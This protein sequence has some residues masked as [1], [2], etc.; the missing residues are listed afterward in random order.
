MTLGIF[1]GL[2]TIDIVYGVEEFPAT[3]KKV[4]AASQS[5]MV[6]GPATNAAIAFSYLGGK[7]ALV[8]AVGC[9]PVAKL[10]HEELHKY[11]IQLVDL[12]PEFDGV[13]VLSSVCVDHQGNRNV[14][15]AN[16]ARIATRAGEVD[17]S[18]I[19]GA[20]ILLADGHYLNDCKAWAAAA[21]M[22]GIHVVLDGGS[23]KEGTDELLASVQTAICSQ[24]FLPPGCGSR[25]EVI[26]YLRSR[27]VESIAITNGAEP[28]HFVSGKSSGTLLVPSVEV[29]DSLGAGDIFHGAFC[30]FASTQHGFIESL[31]EAAKIASESCRYA[32]TR[33]WMKHV[34]V[35]RS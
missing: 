33:E 3:N 11:S 15:S 21:R 31:A 23:W 10:V 1:T 22:R 24:D 4:A 2:S 20:G 32:G 19:E 35:E 14:V 9:N 16:A 8:T 29:V 18:L 5:V 27:G 7:A 12:S 6:G 17:R 26:A 30:Y 34:Q 13:P 25:D 28:V